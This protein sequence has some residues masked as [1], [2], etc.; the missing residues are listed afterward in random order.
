MTGDEVGH[1]WGGGVSSVW[2]APKVRFLNVIEHVEEWRRFIMDRVSPDRVHV[3]MRSWREPDYVALHS[4][5]PIDLWLIDGY[6]RID[7]LAVVEKCA[8]G[9]DIVVCDD[10]ADYLVNKP[11]HAKT[12]S[13]PHPYAGIPINHRKYGHIR[14]TT[15]KVHHAT[16]DTVIWRV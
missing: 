8:K 1:E 16:K 9:G 7:C 5:F 14:N 12:F 15:L 6:R 10:A 11:A 4:D 2:L 3:W 13:I